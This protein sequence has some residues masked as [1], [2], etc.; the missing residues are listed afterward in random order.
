MLPNQSGALYICLYIWAQ[1]QKRVKISLMSAVP[2]RVSSPCASKDESVSGESLCSIFIIPTRDDQ[3]HA[4]ITVWELEEEE[5]EEEARVPETDA[6][7]ALGFWLLT[8]DKK[9]R[10]VTLLTDKPDDHH[11]DK[12]HKATP[13]ATKYSITHRILL[14]RVLLFP[15]H[16]RLMT[17]SDIHAIN[18]AFPHHTSSSKRTS[19]RAVNE[20]ARECREN[21]KCYF[22]TDIFFKQHTSHAFKSS[23]FHALLLLLL[24]F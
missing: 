18:C 16:V 11:L 23:N 8:R 19:A 1:N 24:L 9:R 10:P 6:S 20:E 15:T 22:S 4:M 12:N 5:E 3:T 7:R 17:R 21:E 2:S 14:L 13:G